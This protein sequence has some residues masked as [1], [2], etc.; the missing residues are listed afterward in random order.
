L[1]RTPVASGQEPVERPTLMERHSARFMTRFG[2][3]V[4]HNS[5]V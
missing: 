4:M 1:V 5:V 3:N 2:V